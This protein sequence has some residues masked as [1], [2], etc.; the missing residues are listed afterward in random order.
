MNGKLYHKLHTTD[1]AV[2]SLHVAVEADQEVVEVREPD[3]SD[4]FGRVVSVCYDGENLCVA[5]YDGSTSLPVEVYV[6]ENG[7]RV[8][9]NEDDA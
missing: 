6:S 3:R 4:R 1:F 8:N 5:C 7:V 9:Y 2:K